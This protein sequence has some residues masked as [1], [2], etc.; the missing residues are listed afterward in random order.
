[1]SGLARKFLRVERRAVSSL[2][3]EYL[4]WIKSLS[5]KDTVE[6]IER[7]DT[8][9]IREGYLAPGASIRDR[10][11]LEALTPE[12]NYYASLINYRIYLDM[13][14]EKRSSG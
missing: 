11:T 12:Q 2:S 9:L 4:D 5:Q 10:A 6:Y 1:L 13:K 7:L 8:A 3:Q 14:Q